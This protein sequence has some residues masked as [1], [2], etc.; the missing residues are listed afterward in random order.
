VGFK[1]AASSN[2]GSELIR[3]SLLLA[4][5]VLVGVPDFSEAVDFYESKPTLV[6]QCVYAASS[7]FT[8]RPRPI[9]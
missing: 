7:S 6:G 8:S 3:V 1:V 2:A 5:G 9:V 4:G